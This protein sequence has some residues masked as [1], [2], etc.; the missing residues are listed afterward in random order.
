MLEVSFYCFSWF[1]TKKTC[2]L[3]ELQSFIIFVSNFNL[4]TRLLSVFI[5]FFCHFTHLLAQY[6]DKCHY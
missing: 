1:F 3:F 4:I 6:I 5:K 2:F